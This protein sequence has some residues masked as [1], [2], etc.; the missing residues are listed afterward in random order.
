MTTLTEIETA[1]EA[2]SPEQKYTLYRYIEGQLQDV[3]GKTSVP[4][5]QSVLDIAPVHLGP[6]LQPLTGDD[7][8][9][10]EMLE[11]RE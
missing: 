1:V 6:V 2:L 10:D 5:R 3:S 4:R 9:L 8:L 7:D 11:T